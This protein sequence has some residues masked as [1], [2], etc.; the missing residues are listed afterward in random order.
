MKD[1]HYLLLAEIIDGCSLLSVGKGV[2][3]YFKHPIVKD[4]LKESLQKRDLEKQADRIGLKNNEELLSIAYNSGR[5][6]KEKDDTIKGLEFSIKS[7]NNILNKI[8]DIH[9]KKTVLQ[10]I[11]DDKNELKKLSNQKTALILA[12]K[13]AFVE[14]KL[15]SILY[16]GRLFYDKSFEN[17][18]EEKDLNKTFKFYIEKFLQLNDRDN[19][20]RVAFCNDFFDYFV[21]YEDISKIFDKPAL[22][23]TIFQKN[24]LIYGNVLI[25][26]LKNSSKMPNEIKLNPIKIYEWSEDGKNRSQD[27]EDFNIR[28]KVKRAG[29]LENMKPEDKIT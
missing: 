26:K 21:I 11:A 28:E 8:Q 10:Q 4:V 27:D 1:I 2:T 5:W 18:L 15:I 12:S 13:E 22:E 29:G 23:L 3:Y 16:S 17:P 9:I 25:N 19:L 24:I 7:K 6:S 20:L 14:K